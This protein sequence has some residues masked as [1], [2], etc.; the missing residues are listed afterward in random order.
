MQRAESDALRAI[1]AEYV[2]TV[3]S[4]RKQHA[5]STDAAL[6]AHLQDWES[7]MLL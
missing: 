6:K 2:C 3:R 5:K 4:L 7:Y 1:A